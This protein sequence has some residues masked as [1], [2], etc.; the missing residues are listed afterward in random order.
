MAPG[1]L[2]NTQEDEKQS[3]TFGT[4]GNVRTAPVFLALGALTLT[5]TDK[6]RVPTEVDD[7]G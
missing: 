1:N 7:H 4:H 5:A 2:N 3:A 6:S